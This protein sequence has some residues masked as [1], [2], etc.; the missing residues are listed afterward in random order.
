MSWLLAAVLRMGLTTAVINVSSPTARRPLR[1]AARTAR[2][3]TGGFAGT[4]AP[5]A[6]PRGGVALARTVCAHAAIPAPV[7][8]QYP[9]YRRL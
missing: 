4:A 1:P 7:P 6:A 8:H 3:H 2:L 5:G 9:F